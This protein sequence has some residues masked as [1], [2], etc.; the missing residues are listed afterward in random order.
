MEWDDDNLLSHARLSI[1]H[2]LRVRW[3]GVPTKSDVPILPSDHEDVTAAL[4]VFQ[5]TPVFLDQDLHDSFYEVR[6]VYLTVCHC[7]ELSAYCRLASVGDAT[8]CCKVV[9]W[10]VE[11]APT[12]VVCV[13]L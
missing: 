10:V 13:W 5:C 2:Q 4:D 3:I 12:R 8:A 6:C 11:V 7:M 1:P 9:L